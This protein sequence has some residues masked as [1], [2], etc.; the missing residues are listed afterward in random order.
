MIYFIISALIVLL[1]Q[2]SK[3][4]MSIQLTPGEPVELI[5]G[6][7]HLIYVE[8]TGAAFSFLRD[9]RWVLVIVSLVVIVLLIVLMIRYGSKIRPLGM[10]ALASVL[11]GAFGNL[12]DRAFFGY[13]V[14]FFEFGFISW[15]AVFNVADS[16][17]TIGGIVFCIYYIFGRDDILKEFSWGSGRAGKKKTEEAGPVGGGPDVDAA[18]DDSG[19][20]HT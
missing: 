20:D 16:F 19:T 15:F 13:V 3:Y 4:M 1:D 5:P 9:M 12:I 17:I 8:N 2:A 10:L 7:I 6:I 11:G 14:D 18:G